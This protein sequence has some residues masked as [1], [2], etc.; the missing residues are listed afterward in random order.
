MN[1]N[2]DFWRKNVHEIDP[3]DIEL[4]EPIGSGSYG[5]VYRGKWKS[6]NMNVAIKKLLTMEKE[7]NILA[8]LKHE[9]II[10]FYGC[11]NEPGNFSLILELA[12][13]GSLYSFLQSPNADKM[14]SRYLLNWSRDI[15]K[16]VEYLHKD[17]PC[18]ERDSF[19]V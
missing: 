5:S 7:A 15:A 6:K 14:D 9:N 19:F 16:G 17:A 13:I 18:K 2:H 4:V 1:K 11:C 8:Q 12:P 3:D 10:E